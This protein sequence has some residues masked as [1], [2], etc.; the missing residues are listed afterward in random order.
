MSDHN[1]V[2]N[3]ELDYYRCES[4]GLIYKNKNTFDLFACSSITS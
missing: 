3:E 2:R 4:C 1:I